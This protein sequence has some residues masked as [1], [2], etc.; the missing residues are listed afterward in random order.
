M[1]EENA[2]SLADFLSSSHITNF[3]IIN[4]P[5]KRYKSILTGP[6]NYA[7]APIKIYAVP[8]GQLVG[9][10]TNYLTTPKRQG[11]SDY[12]IVD[13]DQKKNWIKLLRFISINENDLNAEAICLQLDKDLKLN[14]FGYRYEHPE[15]FGAQNAPGAL[16]HAF[17]HI[18]PIIMNHEHLPFHG[19]IRWLPDGF[20]AFFMFA[21]CTYELLI[22]A[23]HSLSGWE[24]LLSYQL[25]HK[26]KNPVLNRL[27]LCGGAA[28]T[29]YEGLSIDRA[30][31]VNNQ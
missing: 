17:F 9:I 2:K 27:L 18:Q 7:N 16:K 12:L 25:K 29:S 14:C 8:Q 28:R 20:P 19:A 4:G 6:P 24:K 26:D 10:L 15:D 31:Q 30:G 21:S 23:L 3:N 13:I 5:L 22:Y 1:D 11:P